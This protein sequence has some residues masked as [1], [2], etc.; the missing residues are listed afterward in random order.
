MFCTTSFSD[1]PMPTAFETA[2]T[3]NKYELVYNYLIGDWPLPVDIRNKASQTGLMIACA[4]KAVET[5]EE[6]IEKN[7]ELDARDT[8]G[9]TA[10]HHAAQSGSWECIKLLIENKAKI[11]ATTDKNETALFFA[12]KQNYP[13]I[14]EFLIEN[15][16]LP[17]ARAVQTSKYSKEEELFVLELAVRNNF[18]EI[19]KCLLFQWT[20]TNTQAWYLN[21]LKIIDAKK[22]TKLEITIADNFSDIARC[23]LFPLPKTFLYQEKLNEL[24]LEAAENSQIQIARELLINGAIVNHK[25]GTICK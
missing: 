13:D 14:V 2:I 19:T 22:F 17:Q 21:S 12:T 10:L 20:I 8:L 3:E 1:K 15:N 23:L 25:G 11:D 24:L 7:P 5:A 6:I 18:V 9:W 4:F 16:C